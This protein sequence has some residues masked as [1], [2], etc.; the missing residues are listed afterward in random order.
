M[1]I[2]GIR[3]DG[4]KENVIK[5]L[6]PGWYPFGDFVEPVWENNYE[7]RKPGSMAENLYQTCDPLPRTISVSC[8]VGANGSGKS[9]LLEML[10]RIINNF[11]SELLPNSEDYKGRKLTFAEGLDAQL[12]FETDGTVGSIL[13]KDDYV[14]YFYG[15]NK[16]RQPNEIRDPLRRNYKILDNF[17]YT[18]STNYSIYSLNDDDYDSLDIQTGEKSSNEGKWLYGLFHKNDGY[19]APITMTPYR[20]EGGIIDVTNEKELARQRLMTLFLLFES[21]NKAFINGYRPLE[22]EYCFNQNYKNDTLKIYKDKVRKKLSSSNV[23]SLI[24][25]FSKRWKEI[26]NKEFKCAHNNPIVEETILFYLGYKTLKICMTY[27]SFGRIINIESF[28][29]A[30]FISKEQVNTIIEKIRSLEEDNHITLKINQCLTFLK[31]GYLAVENPITV[32]AKEFIK[33]NLDFDNQF[34]SSEDKKKTKY[35]TYDQV[36]KLLPPP[37]FF[38]DMTLHRRV[39]V[40]ETKKKIKEE[41]R[42]SRLSSGEKQMLFNLSYVIYHIKNIQSVK[43]DEYRMPYRHINLIFD[44]AELYFHPEF[45]RSFVSELL[46]M[47]SWCHIDRRKIRSINIIIVTHSPFVLSDV[48]LENILYLEDGRHV[49]KMQQTF[50][51]NI[52]EILQSH[53]FMKYPMGEIAREVL[54]RIITLYGKRDEDRERALKDLSDNKDYYYYVESIIAD[55]YLKST[56]H[57]MLNELYSLDETPLQKL[58]REREETESKLKNIDNQ[59]AELEKDEKN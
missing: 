23:D 37:F 48:P 13:N 58:H 14:R 30:S 35:D 59:I 52:H 34:L 16:D 18:I 12:Y 33:H 51:A 53:F 11:A 20:Q 26:I 2:I 3:L 54:D 50:S 25:A 28:S 40:R 5:N 29:D 56:I 32:N 17:F 22:L 38:C 6:Q 1:H 7:W 39:Q 31:R 45:Q 47:I 41:I 49:K 24:N 36:F 43:K 44:E 19:L 46:K 9:T 27:E 42:L 4:G 21:Q 8:V 55:P 10:F 15:T 57:R